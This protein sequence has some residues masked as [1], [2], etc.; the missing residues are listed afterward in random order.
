MALARDRGRK[1]SQLGTNGRVLDVYCN[2]AYQMSS[3]GG[4]GPVSPDAIKREVG[5]HSSIFADYGQHDATEFLVTLLDAIHEDLNQAPNVLR[6]MPNLHLLDGMELHRACNAS[7]VCELFHGETCTTLTFKCGHRQLVSE[8]LALWSL[9]LPPGKAPLTLEDCVTAWMSERTMVGDNGLYCDRCN[10][11]ADTT[12]SVRVVR[13]P[14]V[15][16]IQLKRFA[17]SGGRLSKINT[18]VSYPI[19]FQTARWAAA[20]PGE[21]HLTAVIKHS[22]T[23]NG[24][25]YTCLVRD[26]RSRE[27]WYDISD[28]SVSPVTS[29]FGER[30]TDSSA[31]SLLY[32]QEP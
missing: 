7:M 31:M 12:R 5:R 20:D 13:F 32:Q 28:S 14:P 9:S 2:F 27:K 26:I 17:L 8:P 15:V 30:M 10:R 6:P 25:H 23:L 3:A 11:V 29:S 24:G 19:K 1:W 21:R 18:S 22:G 16:I 4:G